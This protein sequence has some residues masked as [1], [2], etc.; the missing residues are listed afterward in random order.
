MND[1]SRVQMLSQINGFCLKSTDIAVIDRQDLSENEN[2]YI[3]ILNFSV[4]SLIYGMMQAFI[5]K[6]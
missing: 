2:K 6:K 1:V 5:S 3:Y 4:Y